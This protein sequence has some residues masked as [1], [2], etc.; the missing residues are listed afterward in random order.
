M[1]IVTS[2]DAVGSGLL[3]EQLIHS[4]QLGLYFRQIQDILLKE[5]RK[6]EQFYN[7]ITEDD[8]AEFINGEIIFHTPVKFEHNR[9]SKLLLVLLDA[10]VMTRDLGFVGYEKIMISLTRNDYEP[11]ICFFGK[12]K[13]DHFTPEQTRFPAPDLI[14]EVL[15]D[16]TEANDRGVKFQDYAA[17]GVNEYWIVD[18]I[19]QIVEQYRLPLEGDLRPAKIYELVFKANSGTL[20]S[21]AVSGFEIPVRAIFDQKENIQVLQKIVTSTP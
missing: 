7:T 2:K 11:D 16:S 14:V 1:T 17:H 8:K 15:S 10:H 21:V 12:A 3:L 13:S 6:R 18:P 4:P 19:R 5:Q 20:K 9:V